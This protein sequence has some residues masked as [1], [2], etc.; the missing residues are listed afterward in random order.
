MQPSNLSFVF[1]GTPDVSSKTLEI[2]KSNG[3]VPSL[4]VTAPDRPIG[5]HFTMTPTPTKVWAMENNIPYLEPEKITE[6][7]VESLKTK[8]HSLKKSEKDTEG[9][10]DLFIVVAYGKILPQ[11]LIDL[12]K[13]GTLNI[14]YSL[15]PKWRGAS[16]VEAAILHGDQ[17][18]GVSIQKMVFKLDAGP[19]IAEEKIAILPTETTQVL[20]ARLIELGGALLS[21]ILPDFIKGTLP[22]REQ[23]EALATRS[24]KIKKEDGLIDPKSDDPGVLWNKYRAYFGWPGLYFFDSEGKRIKITEAV[25]EHDRFVIKKVIPE[26]KKEM[27]WSN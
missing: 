14:H 20:R 24:G 25:F 17:E 11:S 10:Y 6:E 1:F 27:S 16:P 7:F 9:P 2:L 23:N 15:L 13:Y 22:L 21:K 26:G 8:R 4:I 5:R 3:Y 12:P 18:T 19:V